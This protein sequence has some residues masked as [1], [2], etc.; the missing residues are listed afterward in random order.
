MPIFQGKKRKSIRNAF[1]C[2][3]YDDILSDGDPN[4]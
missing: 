3:Q 1:L 2:N 4:T